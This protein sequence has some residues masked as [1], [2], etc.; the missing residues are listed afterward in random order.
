GAER[1][2]AAD[3][4]HLEGDVFERI[5][6]EQTLSVGCQADFISAQH[7]LGVHVVNSITLGREMIDERRSVFYPRP[8]SLYQ[9][10]KVVVL[11]EVV[12]RLD[13]DASQFAAEPGVLDVLDLAR[14]IDFAVPNFQ[15]RTLC[16]AAH[17][18]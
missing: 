15:R 2:N 16:Q 12:A 7:T 10:G 1:A 13:Q 9:M 3:A 17:P 14:K 18:G 11:R 5:A 8:L 4:D 6:I